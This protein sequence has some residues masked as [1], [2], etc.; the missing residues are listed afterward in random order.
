MRIADHE[1]AI[2]GWSPREPARLGAGKAPGRDRFGCWVRPMASK[3][4]QGDG[5]PGKV[6]VPPSGSPVRCVLTCSLTCTNPHRCSRHNPHRRHF[7]RGFAQSGFNEVRPAPPRDTVVVPADLTEPSRLD[8]GLTDDWQHM[9][10]STTIRG[11]RQA[12]GAKGGLI[13]RLLVDHAAVLRAKSTPDVT[14]R[15]GL[16]ASS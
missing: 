7:A 10:D 5:Y 12:A 15:D 14:I 16:S 2:G 13:R 6:Q 1:F 3:L 9:I 11:H 4:D 8:L